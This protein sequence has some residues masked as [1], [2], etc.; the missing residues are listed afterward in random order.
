MNALELAA[1]LSLLAR[2]LRLGHN[3]GIDVIPQV[4]KTFNSFAEQATTGTITFTYNSKTYTCPNLIAKEIEIGQQKGKLDA[5]KEYKAR[6]GLSLLEAKWTVEQYFD[7]YGYV[8][9]RQT[10]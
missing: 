2:F 6:T 7:K 8:F 4:S 3:L 5:V 9:Y 1:K 10:W